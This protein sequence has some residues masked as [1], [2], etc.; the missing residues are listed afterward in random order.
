MYS[1]F[2]VKRW[3]ILWGNGMMKTILPLSLICLI[4]ATNLHAEMIDTADFSP[5]MSVGHWGKG[6]TETIGQ[7]FTV[8]DDNK[9][10]NFTFYIA[11]SQDPDYI[12]FTAYVM[13]WNV[14]RA[15]GPVLFQSG[16][17]RTTN[18]GGLGGWEEF[19]INT[20]GLSL[21]AG[22]QYVAFFSSSGYPSTPQ[23]RGWAAYAG[24]RYAD[25]SFVYFDN[26]P[27]I[28][29]LTTSSWVTNYPGGDLAF[30]MTL[31]PLPGAVLLGMI[32]LGVA[33]VKLRKRA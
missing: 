1:M 6:S 32:G 28:S 14:D 5:L 16:S 23:G 33:G 7:T 24:E 3:Q 19:T 4:A 10:E 25:G 27:S 20:G 17:L 29:N 13:Q 12:D 30:E 31:V 15:M 9:L 8:G 11:D 22:E 18:N 21:V 2:H 26:G